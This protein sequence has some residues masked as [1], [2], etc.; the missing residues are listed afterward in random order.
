[1]NCRTVFMFSGQGSQYYQMGRQLFDENPVFR[2]WMMRLDAL[3]HAA[4]GR[5]VV[6]AIYGSGKAEIFDQTSLTHPAIF[7]V[8][9]AL[10]QCLIAQ[11]TR[12]DMTLGS[13]LGSFAA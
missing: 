12:P 13:S 11:G 5:R 2:E 6:N 4:T 8:E 3:A 9:F 10:A 1:M 7:M